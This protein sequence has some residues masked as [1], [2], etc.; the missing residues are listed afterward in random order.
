[1]GDEGFEAGLGITR[2]LEAL[3]GPNVNPACRTRVYT[4]GAR[5]ERALLLLHGFTNCPQQFDALGT[6]FHGGAGT[7]SFLGI[8]AMATPTG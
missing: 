8:R 3:D 1:M 2:E 5:T 4:H 6:R 7:C